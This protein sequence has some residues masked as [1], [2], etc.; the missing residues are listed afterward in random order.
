MTAGQQLFV[1]FGEADQ[2]I[3]VQEPADSTVA[4]AYGPFSSVEDAEQA[5]Q[6]LRDSGV[7]DLDVIALRKVVIG[8]WP[9]TKT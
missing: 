5:L 6:T 4:A 9:T 1:Q 8:P 7:S 2:W 3:L